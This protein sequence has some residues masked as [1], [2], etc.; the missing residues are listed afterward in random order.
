MRFTSSLFNT[1]FLADDGKIP[2]R[3][4]IMEAENNRMAEQL[5][6]KVSRLKMVGER[7]IIFWPF[8][9]LNPLLHL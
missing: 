6:S 5:S 8:S 3:E 9:F 4:E 2:N 1:G 7:L